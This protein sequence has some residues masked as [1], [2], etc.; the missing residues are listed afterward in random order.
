MH[1]ERKEACVSIY[2]GVKKILYLLIQGKREPSRAFGQW[3]HVAQGEKIC[4]HYI[5]TSQTKHGPQFRT[6]GG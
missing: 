4:V 5:H 2:L 3:D 1:V 6:S